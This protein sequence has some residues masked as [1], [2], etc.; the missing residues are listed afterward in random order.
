N[1]HD[2]LDFGERRVVA[3]GQ[4]LPD[5][6]DTGLGAGFEIAFESGLWPALIGIDDKNSVRRGGA[7]RREPR[8]IA[9]SREFDFEKRVPARLGRRRRHLGRAAGRDREGGHNR[10]G[11]RDA[12][13]HMSRD[14]ASLGIE[15]PER[16]IERI[17]GGAWWQKALER[18]AIRARLDWG[19]HRSYLGQDGLDALAVAAIG[20]AFAAAAKAPG[21]DRRHD[22]D[23]F[24]LRTARDHEFAKDWE[25]FNGNI[26]IWHERSKR[27]RLPAS[28]PDAVSHAAR[29]AGNHF[30][31][32]VF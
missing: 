19:A 6:D 18:A 10:R 4:R 12:R 14:A 16:A 5:Q 2:M 9:F 32:A 20:N 23:R 3:R 31:H 1:R 21:L 15:I 24:R 8:R 25:A 22:H 30:P 11:G 7:H 26:E 13:E 29:L 27:R 17:A 28:L